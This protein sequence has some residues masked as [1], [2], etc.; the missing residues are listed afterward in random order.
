MTTASLRLRGLFY[1]EFSEHLQRIPSPPRSDCLPRQPHAVLEVF[2]ATCYDKQ[3]SRIHEH[4]IQDGRELCRY[5]IS[6]REQRLER[7]RVLRRRRA[8]DKVKRVC[9]QSKVSRT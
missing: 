5:I 6:R 4:N 1:R 8:L 3:S 2:S 7:H 9:G